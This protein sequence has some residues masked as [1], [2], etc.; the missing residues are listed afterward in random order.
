MSI[1]DGSYDLDLAKEAAARAEAHREK[2]NLLLIGRNIIS[3]ITESHS[4]QIE[5]T[6]TEEDI[7]ELTGTSDY[8]ETNTVLNKISEVISE[9]AEKHQRAASAA[10]ETSR[11]IRGQLGND[12]ATQDSVS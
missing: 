1:E 9:A 4:D 8:R 2:H 6:I 12:S 7:G 3:R 10:D 11:T 5:F